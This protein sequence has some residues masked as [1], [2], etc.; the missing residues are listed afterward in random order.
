MAWSSLLAGIGLCLSA[1][2]CAQ[3][4]S[5]PVNVQQPSRAAV[6]SNAGEVMRSPQTGA[7]QPIA[8]R[9]WSVGYHTFTEMT[10]MLRGLAEAAGQAVSLQSIATTHAGREVWLLR[11]AA[12][13]DV[14]PDQRQALLIT[15]GIDADHPAGSETAL[16]VTR[17]LVAALSEEPD[18]DLAE[19]LRQRTV[20]V[21]PRLNPDGIEA[22]FKPLRHAARVNT[23]GSSPSCA[24]AIPRASGSS[25]PTSLAS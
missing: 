24:P 9:D 10:A 6:R 13:G 25:I 18:G 14:P 15:G 5:P 3:S 8:P 17:R 12:V 11:V 4:Q 21:V 16:N 1:A 20:Y 7:V 2:S 22:F 23:R 19:M